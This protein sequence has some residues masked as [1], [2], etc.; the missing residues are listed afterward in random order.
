[1]K[2][3][4]KCV[5]VNQPTLK[6]EKQTVCR[7]EPK[8]K[9]QSKTVPVCKTVCKE[10]PKTITEITPQQSCKQVPVEKCQEIVKTETVCEPIQVQQ[11]IEITDQDSCPTTDVIDPILCQGAISDCWTPGKFQ[12][13]WMF[14]LKLLWFLFILGVHDVD[15]PMGEGKFGLCCFNGCVNTC[16]TTKIINEPKL[17]CY[18]RPASS[19]VCEMV[20]ETK[21]KTVM[22]PV[23]KT[24]SE[25]VCEPVCHNET[26]ESCIEVP[27]QVC[28]EVPTLVKHFIPKEICVW[29]KISWNHLTWIWQ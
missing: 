22:I 12:V 2:P 17:N 1:M 16:K 5:I 20:P 25:T 27:E 26:K 7:T 23:Q 9:C 14:L 21:C 4:K 3:P 24:V 10:I 29:I 18:D 11:V 13:K 8:K 28:Q 15:C 6:P 19:K